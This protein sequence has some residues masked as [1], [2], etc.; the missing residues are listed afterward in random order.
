[1]LKRNRQSGVTLIELM[2]A[3]TIGLVMMAGAISLFIQGK[4]SYL[5][6]ER[7]TRMQDDSRFALGELT[8]DLANAGFW[9]ELPAA[10]SI[11]P[12][13]SLTLAVDC[14]PP[15]VPWVYDFSNALTAVDNA[16]GANAA[17]QF[18][19][20]DA[21]VV[22]PGADVIGVKRTTGNFF[23]PPLDNGAV[24]VKSNGVVGLL[25]KQPADTPPAVNVPAPSSDWLYSPSV[26]YVRN[27][28][29]D[30]D[31]AD[32]IPTLCRK[33][34]DTTGVPSM[35]EEC[36]ARGV[37]DLQI[38][39]GIDTNGD[40]AAD[41]YLADPTAVEL[42][43]VVAIRVFLLARSVEPQ[44]GYHNSKSYQL[45]NRP[46]ITPDDNF[47]RRVYTATITTRNLRNQARFGL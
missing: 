6:N 13:A 2:I 20:I 30:A 40:A 31:R 10:E 39:F 43:R 7:I 15:G 29:S 42:G 38:E 22:Q 14:G 34:L 18:G 33:M 5:E 24:Y 1:M 21:A 17:A 11:T 8:R 28:A 16:T 35:V 46:V 4:R 26:W 27:H 41:Q 12:D 25:F 37:E 45:G 36:I 3:M 47:Y 19:C 44:V 32:G 9:G 23:V